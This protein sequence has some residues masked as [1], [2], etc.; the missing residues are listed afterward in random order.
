M[1]ITQVSGTCS[2]GSIPGEGIFYIREQG[3]SRKKILIVEDNEDNRTILRYRLL[4]IGDFDIR[5][6]S[7]GKEALALL[8]QNAP[9]LILLDLKLPVLDGWETARRIRSQAGPEKNVPIIA[10][11]AQ[12][13]EG[14]EEKA[15]AAGCNDYI[16]KPVIDAN[17]I[18]EKVLKFLT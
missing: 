4:K 14:D 15:L 10:L 9:D 3:M 7:N 16:P 6:A 1:D 12:A 18:K 17:V 11:T 13:M 5:E 2:L 8:A